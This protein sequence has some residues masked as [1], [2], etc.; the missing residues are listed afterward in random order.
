M[1]SLRARVL[2]SVLVL[3]AAGLIALAAV[4]YAEQ[5][6][7]LLGR[8]DQEATAAR[9]AVSQLLDN[10]GFR[11]SAPGLAAGGED[12]APHAGPGAYTQHPAHHT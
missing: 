12:H 11:P 7:F 2:A 4:T 6:S 10:E 5:R 9:V 8:V 1:S 3:A